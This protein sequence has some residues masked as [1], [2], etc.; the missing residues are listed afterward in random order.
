[1]HG[2]ISPNLVFLYWLTNQLRGRGRGGGAAA[3]LQPLSHLPAERW[4]ERGSS[5]SPTHPSVC[6]EAEGKT[7]RKRCSHLSN[8]SATFSHLLTSQQA[9]VKRGFKAGDWCPYLP[10]SSQSHDTCSSLPGLLPPS[11]V[12]KSSPC[13]CME[14]NSPAWLLALLG[15]K[16]WP[17]RSHNSM[18]VEWHY[19]YITNKLN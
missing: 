19:I 14:K 8:L 1:M 4:R 6:W 5:P 9:E 17:V 12:R 2:V 15:R 10:S 16:G 3:D 7:E 18:V 11:M 13:R